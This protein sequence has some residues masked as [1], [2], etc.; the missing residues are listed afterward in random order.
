MFAMIAIYSLVYIIAGM[1]TVVFIIVVDSETELSNRVWILALILSW[2]ILLS[3]LSWPI[4]LPIAL[5]IAAARWVKASREGPRVYTYD[6]E[7]EDP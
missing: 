3:V 4:L 6:D 2:P 5:P 1:V 7:E